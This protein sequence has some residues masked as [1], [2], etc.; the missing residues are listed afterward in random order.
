M[1]TMLFFICISIAA[2]AQDKLLGTLPLEDGKVTYTQVHE[3]DSTGKDA[4]Y[5][6]AKKWLAQFYYA[7]TTVVQFDE[8][9]SGE[10]IALVSMPLSWINATV[11]PV[12][13]DFTLTIQSK[14]NK[15]RVIAS[16]IKLNSEPI[17]YWSNLK[18]EENSRKFF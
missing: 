5:T 14:D 8:K 16:G 6:K 3:I 1:K 10:I 17:E 11:T 15:Y 18:R 13:V 2:N 4:L 9:E 12:Q 7:K